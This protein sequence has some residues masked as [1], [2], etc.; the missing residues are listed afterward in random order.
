ML[1]DCLASHRCSEASNFEVMLNTKG[2]FA[3]QPQLPTNQEVLKLQKPTIEERVRDSE[4]D[5]FVHMV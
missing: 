5:N 2:G 4:H 1:L 3:R